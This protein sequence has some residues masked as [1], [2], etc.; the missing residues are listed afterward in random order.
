MAFCYLLHVYK[1]MYFLFCKFTEHLIC[2]RFCFVELAHT[3]GLLAEP[4][5]IALCEW[6]NWIESYMDIS[7]DLIGK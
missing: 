5:Y 4:D 1:C 6:Y 2:Y 3:N 7:L